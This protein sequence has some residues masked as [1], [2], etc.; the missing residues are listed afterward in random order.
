MNNFS[1]FHIVDIVAFILILVGLIRGL[2]KGLSGELAGLLGAAAA[3]AGAWYFYTPLGNFLIGKTRL[4]ERASMAVA[5]VLALVGA[6][7]AARI[8]RLVL[9]NLM[10]FSFKGKI[11]KIGGLMAGGIRM[12]VVVTAFVLLVTLWPH[13]YL[14]RLFAEESVFGRFVFEKLGPVY[15]KIADEHPALK[16]PN[17][18]EPVEDVND[19]ESMTGEVGRSTDHIDKH[20][21]E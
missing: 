9:R 13:E 16:I 12:A 1:Y 15:E 19:R 18:K 10:E 5:F 6:Y 17:Q 14:H 20:R 2:V 11:E 8:L 4:S 21:S 7:L 3:F